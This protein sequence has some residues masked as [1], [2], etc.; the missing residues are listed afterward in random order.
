MN[1]MHLNVPKTK[2]KNERP[3]M[4]FLKKSQRKQRQEFGNLSHGF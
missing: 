3:E 1:Q 2:K 4:N